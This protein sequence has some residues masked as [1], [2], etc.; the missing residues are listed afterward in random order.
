MTDPTAS[1]SEFATL[2]NV[3]KSRVSHWIKNG[4]LSGDAIVG[5]GRSA[6]IHIEIGMAQVAARRDLAQALGNGRKTR[7]DARPSAP[8]PSAPADGAGPDDDPN[9]ELERALLTRENRIA[10]EMSNAVKKGDLIPS[11]AV[12]ARYANLTTTIRSRM[13]TVSARVKEALPK[14]TASDVATVDAVVRAVL[15]EASRADFA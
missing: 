9:Y 8:T 5:T 7:V 2:C 15:T 11:A 14:L 6:R 4:T 13:L 1:K 3:D 12:E 10:R